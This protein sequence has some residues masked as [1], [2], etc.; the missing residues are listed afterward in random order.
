MTNDRLNAAVERLLSDS[1][2]LRRFRRHPERTLAV[3]ELTHE[4]IEAVKRGDAP[5]LLALG[6]DPRLVWP[7][8]QAE[9]PLVWLVSRMRPLSPALVLAALLAPGSPAL[10]AGRR[11]PSRVGRVARYFAGRGVAGDFFSMIARTGRSGRAISRAANGRGGRSFAR[12]AG[13]FARQRGIEPP[14]GGETP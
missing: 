3:Y 7:R 13:Q 8:V 14:P 11:E 9:S 5:E 10:A 4:E 2:F 1:R 12:S 6:L